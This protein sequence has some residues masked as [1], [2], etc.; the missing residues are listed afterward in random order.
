MTRGT[1]GA[2]M[3]HLHVKYSKTKLMLMF[4]L[5]LNTETLKSITCSQEA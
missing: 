5:D 4:K 1:L 2:E 3:S